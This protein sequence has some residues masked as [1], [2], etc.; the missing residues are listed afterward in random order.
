MR[1]LIPA[2]LGFLLAQPPMHSAR[3]DVRHLDSLDGHVNTGDGFFFALPRTVVAADVSV[4]LKKFKPGNLAKYAI[5]YFP[6]T[7]KNDG[8]PAEPSRSFSLKDVSF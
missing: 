7:Y 4:D 5:V 8:D 1:R 2:V 6:E 3:I